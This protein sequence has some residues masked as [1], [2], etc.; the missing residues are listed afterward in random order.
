MDFTVRNRT[1]IDLSKRHSNFKGGRVPS[2]YIIPL[3][4]EFHIWRLHWCGYIFCNKWLP[5]HRPHFKRGG[6]ER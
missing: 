6:Y 2:G 1:K 5:N 4:A 3:L